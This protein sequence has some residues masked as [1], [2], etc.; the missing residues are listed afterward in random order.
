M[1]DLEFDPITLKVYTVA[2]NNLYVSSND[3]T[4]WNRVVP[5]TPSNLYI[6]DLMIDGS[7]L[8]ALYYYQLFSSTDGGANWTLI[9]TNGSFDGAY[10]MIKIVTGVYAVYGYNG[11]YV[12]KD[13][14]VTWTQ[15]TTVYAYSDV[16]NSNGDLYISDSDGIK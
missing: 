3:G 9:N 5:T 2:N 6:S 7:T 1:N 11:V 15:I 8:F 12:S 13:A 4:A 14:G 16:V 10:K